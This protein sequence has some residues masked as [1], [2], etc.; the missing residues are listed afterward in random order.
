MLAGV[1]ERVASDLE[2]LVVLLRRWQRVQNLVSR[3]T[4][5]SVW[6]RHIADSL[7]LLPLLRD[8]DRLLV[9]IGSGGGFPALP[10]AIASRGTGR[11]VELVEPNARKA[12]FL[13]TAIREL[14][15][16]ADV[17]SC[18]VE[19]LPPRRPD[20]VTS[21]A[22]APLDDLFAACAGILAPPARGIF[23]KGREHGEEVA[24]A[25]RR[26]GF[27]LEVI[28]SQTDEAGVLLVIENLQPL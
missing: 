25:R 22:F 5:G 23:H 2:H 8:E 3:E 15:L 20:V 27:D 12:S 11:R 10:L 21:R 4:L 16:E 26:F 7:Q 13:R 9:D 6:T 24:A 19:E 14:E 28:R 18:R 17:H 1:P